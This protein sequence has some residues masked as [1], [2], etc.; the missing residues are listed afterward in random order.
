[1]NILVT[2]ATG[3]IGSYVTE[4]LLAEG[5]SVF[6][7]K[8]P[9]S[10]LW[11]LEKIRNKL[12]FVTL[13]DSSKIADIF[14]HHRIEMVIHLAGVYLKK[15]Q[16]TSDIYILNEAN[17]NYP[18]LLFKTA[19]DHGVKYIIN[20][21][22]CFEYA[23]QNRKLTE[24]DILSPYNYYAATKIVT[25]EILKYYAK[26]YQIKAITL[27]PFYVY[28]EKDNE[29]IITLLTKSSISQKS[30]KINNTRAQLNFTYVK[31]VA[32]AYILAMKYLLKTNQDYQ[33]FN[34]GTEKTY[35]LQTVIK[36]INKVSGNSMS[37]IK[38][39]AN[40]GDGIIH[41]NC[42]NRRAKQILG[43]KPSYSLEMA[44]RKM[45]NYYQTHNQ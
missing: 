37:Q 39:S 18:A 34:I 7:V 43:W 6:C 28:G 38:L 10:S 40:Q 44:V 8:R 42:S 32:S 27:R 21:G 22:S 13:R 14:S 16:N 41:M 20:T 5:Y 26:K 35:N 33:V 36:I 1:M 23:L 15:E 45:Y 19:I 9:E 12:K 17:I 31:D 25:E 3:F 30:L 4:M 2:G 24:T 29:K 11:R